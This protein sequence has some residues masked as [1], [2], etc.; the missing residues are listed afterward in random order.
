MSVTKDNLEQRRAQLA[1]RRAALSGV[2]RRELEGLLRQGGAET[3]AADSIPRRPVGEPLPLSFAQERLW[4]LDQLEP[5][6][7]A[8]NV[9]TAFRVTGALNAAALGQA[10]SEVV[11]RHEALRT[12]FVSIDGSPVQVVAEASSFAL[13]I[14]DLSKLAA[15][16]REEAV[17][18]LAA[19][20]ARR[21]FDLT[22]DSLLR[23]ALFRLGAEEHALSVLLHHIVSDA[24]S[25]QVLIREVGEIYRAYTSGGPSPI[26][27]LPVQYADYSLWQR[28]QLQ[29]ETLDELLAYWREQ[30]RGAPAALDLPTDKPR[31]PVLSFRGDAVHFSISEELTERLRGLCREEGTTL[32]SALLASFQLFLWRY[33]G[34]DDLVVGA[35]VAGRPRVE[36]EGLIGFFVNTLA[37]RG[38]VRPTESLRE[39]LSR[40]RETVL[41]A[42]AHA[43]LPFERLVEEVAPERTLSR[44]PLFQAMLVLENVPKSA[45]EVGGIGLSVLDTNSG[46]EK[47]DLTLLVSEGGGGLDCALSYSTDLFERA[48]AERMARHW[49]RALEAFAVEPDRRLHEVELL[50]D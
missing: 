27:E 6:S 25:M 40:A 28:R 3:T 43:E 32:F 18:R 8:Y 34:Q 14:V 44:G 36:T 31:P 1:A 9:P 46:A 50:A 42:Q 16:A 11:R 23:V 21:P 47:F 26:E 45:V 4:F 35:P 33:T 19:E 12:N 22:T 7:T 2:K 24:W 17:R 37:L 29:G 10:L 39:S 49:R 15:P 5:G 38:Q 48:T 41:G 13:P 30:L 20:D